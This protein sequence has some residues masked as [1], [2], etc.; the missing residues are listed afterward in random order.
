MNLRIVLNTPKNPY[1]NQATPKKYSPNFPTQKNPG[2]KNFKHQKL[3]RSSP[4]LEI[5]STPPPPP[6]GA[7]DFSAYTELTPIVFL[8]VLFSLTIRQEPQAHSVSFVPFHIRWSRGY[9]ESFLSELRYLS[10]A[11]SFL[12]FIVAVELGKG[13]LFLFIVVYAKHRWLRSSLEVNLFDSYKLQNG[14]CRFD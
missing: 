4:S 10:S 3:L 12:L 5:R 7:C 1:L 9:W 13:R 6:P 8:I 11:R 14:D 2:I